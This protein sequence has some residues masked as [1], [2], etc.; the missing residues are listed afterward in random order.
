M[1]SKQVS[2]DLGDL[3]L[4]QGNM[5]LKM[6]RPRGSLESL[7]SKD[8][9]KRTVTDYDWAN[10]HVFVKLDAKDDGGN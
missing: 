10:P 2:R 5:R 9:A 7:S 6:V 4:G 3:T 1:F 8:L